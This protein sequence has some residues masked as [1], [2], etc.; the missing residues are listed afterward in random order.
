MRVPLMLLI[1]CATVLLPAA[2]LAEPTVLTVS[3]TDW[4]R[5]YAPVQMLQVA[6]E[7]M[8]CH[9]SY[10]ELMVLSGAAFRSCWRDRNYNF[11]AIVLYQEDPIQVGAMAVGA[12]ASRQQFATPDAAFEA[13][14]ESIDRGAP[15]IAWD[16][17]KADTQVICGY[18]AADGTILRKTLDTGAGEPERV[19]IERARALYFTGVPYELWILSYEEREEPQQPDWLL[20]LTNAVRLSQWAPEDRAYEHFICGDAAYQAWATDM[21]DPTLHEQFPQAGAVAARLAWHMQHARRAAVRFLQSNVLIHPKVLEAAL[22]YQ[23]EALL[24]A[25][26]QQVLGAGTEFPDAEA[27]RAANEA[28][29]DRNVRIAAADLIEQAL[30]KHQEASAALTEAIDALAEP[31]NDDPAG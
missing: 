15:V 18:D 29:E 7:S 24:F 3:S 19:P 31:V 9:R 17:G 25:E 8:G 30:A 6:L 1:V 23:D 5:P 10:E 27:G 14:A 13:I 2:A 26:L 4:D 16:D 22:L 21:L 20:M 28:I 11:P 12:D